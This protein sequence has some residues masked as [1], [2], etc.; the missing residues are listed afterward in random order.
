MKKKIFKVSYEGETKRVK[1][2]DTYD[3]FSLD[4]RSKFQLHKF[5]PRFY[6]LDDEN[7]LISMTT[8]S[9][10]LE[11]VELLDDVTTLKVVIALNA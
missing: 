10:Y 3:H 9:D 4:V 1:P 11:A 8:A 2:A 5:V 7:E 6:Y